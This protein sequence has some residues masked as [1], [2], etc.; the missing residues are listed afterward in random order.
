MLGAALTMGPGPD[1][2]LL[3]RQ[4]PASASDGGEAPSDPVQ[5]T[6]HLRAFSINLWDEGETPGASLQ[7]GLAIEY[8]DE[9]TGAAIVA[10]EA[11]L[12]NEIIEVVSGLGET[13]LASAEGRRELRR[14][15]LDTVNDQLESAPLVEAIW[16]TDL[17]IRWKNS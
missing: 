11:R 16:I 17:H 2:N 1:Q 15:L 7:L 9:N 8:K 10:R 5:L 3:A 12:R 6:H 13:S 4:G 14:R